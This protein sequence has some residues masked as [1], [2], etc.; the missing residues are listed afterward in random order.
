MRAHDP[1]APQ[2]PQAQARRRPSPAAD[3]PPPPAPLRLGLLVDAPAQPAWVARAL[4]A[5]ADAGAARVVLVVVI[6]GATPGAAAAADARGTA[7][8]RRAGRALGRLP[9]AL[10]SRVDGARH[11]VRGDA[12]PREDR[13]ARDLSTLL[14]AAAVLHARAR[15]AAPGASPHGGS[16]ADHPR[17]A[18]LSDA[19]VAAVERHGID[20]LLRLGPP[21]L[22]G[23]VLAAAR[24]GV[25]WLAQGDDRVTRGGPH[26]FWEIAL[27]ERTTGAALRRLTAAPGGGPVLARASWATDPGSVA[28]NVAGAEWRAAELLVGELQRVQRAGA[29]PSARDRVPDPAADWQPYDRPLRATPGP[30]ATTRLWA[31]TSA[32]VARRRLASLVARDQWFIAYHLAPPTPD[33]APSGAPATGAPEGAIHQYRELRPPDDRYWAD[34]FPVDDGERR[35]IFYEDHAFGAPHAHISVVEL[36]ADG[37]PGA[38]TPV[39]RRDYHLSYP[40][41]FCWRGEWWMTP[42]SAAVGKVQLFRATRFP[43]EWE[44][45]ADLLDG[46]TA[47][48][49]T[50][51]EVDGRWWMFVATGAPG[52]EPAALRLYSAPSPLGPWRPHPRNPLAIDARGA[53]PAGRVFWSNGRLYRPG[54][55]GT[56][57]YGSAVVVHRVDVLTEDDYRETPVARIEPAWRPGLVGTHTLNA[58]GRL[59]AI[60][61]RERRRALFGRLL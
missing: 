56:P 13:P 49:P 23:R 47:V 38:H 21:T 33:A 6:E 58:W 4:H 32:R 52:V 50:L 41:V 1:Q 26:G 61:A 57:T 43:Y 20:V 46:V 35:W 11:G 54:Q 8:L 19:D 53:R 44:H 16:G 29:G 30:L 48:D 25:W 5:A 3:G 42:E 40:A 15:P 28:A 59:S 39:L 18:E 34:P 24:H 55:D 12:P 7:R 36:R 14:Q 27:G 60:D 9:Y 37:T 2:A 17:R 51:V 45:A 10:Y 22:G 31:R